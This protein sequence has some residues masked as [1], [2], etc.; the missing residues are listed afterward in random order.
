VKGGK[1]IDGLVKS[2]SAALR[3]M[4]SLRGKARQGHLSSVFARLASEACYE[5]IALL[6]FYETIIIGKIWNPG[7]RKFLGPF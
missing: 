1:I 4:R 3:F 6:T 5:T 2:P 7:L